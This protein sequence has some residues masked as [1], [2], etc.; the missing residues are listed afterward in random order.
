MKPEVFLATHS[1]F[2]RTEFAASL[3]GRAASTVA[4]HL[5]RWCR[6]GR[7][8]KVKRGLFVRTS[9]SSTTS[10]LPPDLIAIASRMAPD[11]AVAYH[12][13]LEV[14]GYAHS[15]YERPTFVTWTKTKPISFEGRRFVPVRPRAPLLEDGRGERWIESA[16][17][18]GVEIR[19]TCLE[20]T[21]ADVLDRPDLAGG[22]EEVWRSLLALPAIDPGLLEEYI[23]ALRC[24]TLVAKVGFFLDSYQAQLAVP[25]GLIERL[26]ARIPRSPVYMDRRRR[27][28]LVPRWGLVV[29]VGF[30]RGN[31]GGPE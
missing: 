19:V 4:S 14:H 22:V 9:S 26:R 3:P 30:F 17:R 18:S 10:E 12:T 1:L 23:T 29:P 6:Q 24:Q 25:G 27:G 15:L 31:M 2:T 5:A 21:I 8:A 11:A 7:I 13:A 16:E 28:R 20:R